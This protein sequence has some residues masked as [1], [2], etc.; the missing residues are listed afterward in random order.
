MLVRRP[1]S[2]AV[3][4][5]TRIERN[6][7]RFERQIQSDQLDA[8]EREFRVQTSLTLRGLVEDC[9]ERAAKLRDR[10][11]HLGALTRSEVTTQQLLD[12][13][14]KTRAWPTI[15][16]IKVQASLE[17]IVV[18]VVKTYVQAAQALHE[19]RIWPAPQCARI[20][21]QLF[22]GGVPAEVTQAQIEEQWTI[23]MQQVKVERE[24]PLTDH[25]SLPLPEV[26]SD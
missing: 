12:A 5:R 16:A 25:P 15:P 21:A 1:S 26:C 10:K 22:G 8:E 13:S 11:A 14:R 7:Q 6:F 3:E 24:H 17:R 19:F 23:V 4:G 20:E 18:V 9:V 2:S